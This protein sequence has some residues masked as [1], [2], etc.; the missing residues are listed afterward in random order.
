MRP[1]CNACSD[2]SNIYADISFGGLGSQDKYTTVITRTKK[3]KHIFQKILD[4][5]IVKCSDLDST[6]VNKMIEKI[7]QFSRS[8]V[9]RREEFMKNLS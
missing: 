7:G 4:A 5:G 2:F 6:K 3:G 9:Q 1:A 8:K